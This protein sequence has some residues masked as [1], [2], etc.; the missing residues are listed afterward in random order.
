M[1]ERHQTISR[2]KFLRFTAGL[3]LAAVVGCDEEKSQSWES[4]TPSARIKLIEERGFNRKAYEKNLDP[5]NELVLA[6]AQFYCQQTQCLR[7]PEE[8][9][10]NVKFLDTFQFVN[11]FEKEE[12]RPLT[13]AERDDARNKR[14]EITTQD[15]RVLFNVPLVEQ[16]IEG[17]RLYNPAL[18]ARLGEAD[19]EAK[20]YG[21]ILFHAFTHANAARRQWQFDGFS[22]RIGDV[23][24]NFDKM[25]GFQF[26]GR[27]ENG[28]S[29][30]IGGA[31]EAMT[32]LT[33]RVI[34]E[35]VSPYISFADR[36][37]DGMDL[38]AQIC[39]TAGISGAEFIRY[40]NELPQEQLLNKWGALKDPANPDQKGAI[41]ALASIGLYVD[42][43]LSIEDAQKAIGQYLY[44]R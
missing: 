1:A 19:L 23:G 22:T 14:A 18:V 16:L 44:T 4:L 37:G 11:E 8:M 2:R 36:Y 40:N 33:A 12:G 29:F 43:I 7:S 32:E 41:L 38:I 17:Y 34:G 13:P 27:R 10:K 42:G 26:E 31:D 15:R 21:S 24:I 25:R 35:R 3:A 20:I 30:V 39:R 28:Q 5:K 9:A 6:V